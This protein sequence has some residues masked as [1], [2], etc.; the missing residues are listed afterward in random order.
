MEYFFFILLVYKETN[1]VSKLSR[2]A[3]V[4]WN[5]DKNIYN[6]QV[7]TIDYNEKTSNSFELRLIKWYSAIEVFKKNILFGVGSGDYNQELVK[8]YHKIDFKKGMVYEYNT[9]NQYLEEFVKFGV[10]GGLYFCFFIGYLIFDSIKKKNKLL[11]K[12]LLLISVFLMVESVFVRQHGVIFFTL[13]VPLLYKY[14]LKKS[15]I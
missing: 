6:H 4:E 2:L 5:I 3:K 12:T 13:F 7:F 10:F 1:F 9:H 11:L 15:K 8:Q 14:N